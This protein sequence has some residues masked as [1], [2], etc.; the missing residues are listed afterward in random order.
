M[1]QE[2]E[3]DPA[4]TR[5]LAKS[6]QPNTNATTQ[7]QDHDL[8]A[9]L[10]GQYEVNLTKLTKYYQQRAKK[11]WAIFGDR[12]TAF[13]HSAVQKCLRRNRIVSIHDAHG[14]ELFDPND[15][16]N[17]ILNYF[18]SI[19]TSSSSNTV[20]YIPNMNVW[21]HADD[22]TN[23]VP[24][25]QEILEILKAMRRNA[26]PGPY[27]FNVAFYV[28]AWPWIGDDV[29]KVVTSFYTSGILPP[30]LNDTQIALIP[31]KLACHIP[32]DFR[33]ISLCN[34]VYKIIAKSLANRLKMHIPDY[35][36]P[37]QQAFI[38]GRRISNNIV[39]PQEIAHS[40][41][42]TSYKSHDFM[43][44]IDLAKAFDR[45]EW[46]CIISA[47]ARKGLNGHFIKLIHACISLPMFSVIINEQSYAKFSGS[48]G[49]RQGC[50]LS[51]YLFVLALSE[52]SL[53]LQEALQA[54]HLTGILLGPN[55]PPIHSLMFADDLI[56]CGK[57]NMCEAQTI[58][59]ILHQFCEN[60][61]QIPSWSKSGILFSKNVPLPDRENIKRIFPAPNI[62]NSFVHLGHPLILPS[63]DRST[64]YGFIYDKFK[65][66]LSSYKANRLPMQRDLPSL[67]QFSPQFLSTTCQIFSSKKS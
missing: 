67:N 43:L 54:N 5:L 53:Q 33:P 11:H 41:S 20:R 21:N 17:E 23:S 66:K 60:T 28:S 37:S 34:V 25:K 22:F 63:K 65:S 4:T 39:V 35:I 14:N 26:S 48:R 1:V 57:T 64:A 36:H 10:V 46:H 44:K 27:G 40:F 38:E 52:L 55:C 19:F 56:V 2:E 42:L 9:K 16:A 12:N 24:D 6:D 8:E 15:I 49:I 61:G 7:Q 31:K 13:F 47:L 30:H 50:P 62:D 59:N 18:R 32:S 29:T 58:S 3:A 51:P 45:I